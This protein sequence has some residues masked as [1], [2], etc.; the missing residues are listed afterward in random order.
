MIQGLKLKLVLSTEPP[1][2]GKVASHKFGRLA[3][4]YTALQKREQ[5]W[6]TFGGPRL[7][8]MGLRIQGTTNIFIEVLKKTNKSISTNGPDSKKAA[9]NPYLRRDPRM[10]ANRDVNRFWPYAQAK[11]AW[12]ARFKS[13]NTTDI[14]FRSFAFSNFDQLWQA[15]MWG[16]TTLQPPQLRSIFVGQS[17]LSFLSNQTRHRRDLTTTPALCLVHRLYNK[18]NVTWR[19]RERYIYRPLHAILY[20]CIRIFFLEGDRMP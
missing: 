5:H 17:T 18:S 14:H 8:Y 15:Q 7:D 13:Q 3:P 6:T 4:T 1:F 12:H 19:E 10:G 20:V 2:L 9:A 11:V 16:I